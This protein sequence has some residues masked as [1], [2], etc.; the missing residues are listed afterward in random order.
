[1]QICKVLSNDLT[2]SYSSEADSLFIGSDATFRNS[3]LRNL[4]RISLQFPA[5]LIIRVASKFGML[6]LNFLRTLSTTL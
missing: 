4:G 6:A 2:P 1:M 3:P 5:N